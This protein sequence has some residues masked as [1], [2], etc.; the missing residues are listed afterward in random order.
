MGV[1]TI[2]Y[3]LLS[4]MCIVT[5]PAQLQCEPVFQFNKE[6]IKVKII[7]PDT[8]EVQGMYWFVNTG[9]D[10]TET[11]IYYPFPVDTTSLYPHAIELQNGDKSKSIVYQKLPKGIEWNMSFP[12]HGNDS[13]FVMYRQKVKKGSGYY[14]VSTTKCWDRP[15]KTADF[16]IL[17]PK[18]FTL[19]FWTFTADSLQMKNDMLVYNSHFESFYPDGEMYL[20]WK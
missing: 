11:V 6:Y 15:L 17:V 7:A 14:I 4:A 13:V 19:T 16:T 8:I 3:Y 20:R 2:Y 18:M 10:N 9:A 1:I 5:L 12:I